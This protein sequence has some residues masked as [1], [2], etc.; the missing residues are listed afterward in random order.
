MAFEQALIVLQESISR[1]V[2]LRDANL[3]PH[4]VAKSLAFHQ[5]DVSKTLKALTHYANWHKEIL[6]HQSKRV[7]IAH[8]HAFLLTEIFTFLPHVKGPDGRPIIIFRGAKDT[9]TIPKQHYAIFNMWYQLWVLRSNP[10]GNHHLFLDFDGYKFKHFRPSEYKMINETVACQPAP[11]TSSILYMCNAS[12]SAIKLWDVIRRILKDIPYTTS[13]FI[14]REELANFMDAS[15][16]S[17]LPVDFGGLRSAEDTRADME[18]FI[19]EEYAREGLRYEPIDIKS[20]N[21]KT[22]KVADVDLSVR[23][24]SAMSV[25]SNV[26]FD[27]LDAQLEKLGLDDLE[28]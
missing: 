8:I 4:V 11:P 25:A 21:W 26:D 28:E 22:Y 2:L 3:E 14:K 18:D 17:Q 23:P 10:D 16:V 6:G 27:Q 20:I 7:S 9:R 24:E 1:D 15:V 12:K 19:R 13:H 5:N